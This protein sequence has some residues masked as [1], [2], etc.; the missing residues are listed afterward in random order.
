MPSTTPSTSDLLIPADLLPRDGRFGAGPSKVRPESVDAL[1]GHGRTI[2]GTS[3]RQAPV[4]DVVRRVRTGMA[5]LFRL[6]D[7]YEVLLGNGGATHFWD[8]AV[9]GLIA[10]RSEHLTFGEFST[11]FA[12]CAARAPFLED[13]HVVPAEPGSHPVPVVRDDVDLYALTHN[14]TSTGVAMEIARPDG[15]TG[16]VAVDATSAA[17]GMEVDPA[18]FDVY[19]FSPQKCFAADGGLWVALCSPVAIERIAS[20]GGAG[21]WVPDV[22]SLPIALENSRQDQTYNTPALATL[23]LLA[24]QVGWMLENGGLAWSAGRSARNASVLYGWAEASPFAAPFVADPR[25]RSTVVGT[26]DL[27][28]EVDGK[29]LTAVL[30]KN[31]VVDTEPYRKL[32]R[33]QIRVGLFPAVDAADVE[34]LTRCVDWVVE[35]LAS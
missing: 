34:A 35:R 28:A 31:G 14:E 24:D 7:G 19:Y 25:M 29:A 16:L 1:A 27:A 32:G 5:D 8:M 10:R 20:L 21:R 22:L 9:A 23:L 26:V 18:A 30:R 11:K 17:G 3:H 4:K 15:A 33:N 13:P 12:S 2:L 6:P